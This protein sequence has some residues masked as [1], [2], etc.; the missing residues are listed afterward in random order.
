M[1]FNVKN[2]VLRTDEIKKWLEREFSSIRTGR[3]TPMLLDLV[4]VESYGTRVPIQQV[5]S[6]SVEDARTLRIAVWDQNAVKALEKA[7]TEA[8]LGVSVVSD[9]GGVRVI[10]P[11]LTS[12]RRVQLLKIAKAKHEE[13]RVSVRGAR[14]EVMKEID[15]LEKEGEM[16]QDEKTRAKEEVQKCVDACNSALTALLELKEKEI[17]S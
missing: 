5:G 14:D 16:S 7:I 17:N 8:D 10:F 3:A 4:Q 13:S 6:V 15:K 1:A 12:E 9:G 2:F 11:E